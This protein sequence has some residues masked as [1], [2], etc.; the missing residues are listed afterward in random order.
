[1]QGDEQCGGSVRRNQDPQQAGEYILPIAP[2][3]PLAAEEGGGE[4]FP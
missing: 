2:P 4:I 3:S 1:M